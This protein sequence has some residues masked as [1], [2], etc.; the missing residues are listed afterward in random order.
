MTTFAT[1]YLKGP[2][3]DWWF[4]LPNFKEFVSLLTAQ[5]RDPAVEEVHEK[6]MFELR[7]ENGAATTYFQELEKLAKLA[8]QQRDEGERGVLVK[9]VRLGVPES[10]TRFIAF[11]GHGVPQTY[12]QWKARII[13]MHEERQ[14][15]WAFDQVT[16]SGPCDSCP[17]Q[18]GSSNTATSHN[19]TGGATSPSLAK[20]TSNAAPRDAASGKWM[21]FAGR[22]E[23]MD[24]GKLHAEGRCFRCKEKGHLGK[25]CPKKQEFK[26]IRS[27]YT[28]KQVKTE[29]VKAEESKV[30]EDLSTATSC[31]PTHSN[32]PA[33]T[34]LA[35]N[36]PHTTSTPVLESPNRYATLAIKECHDNNTTPLKGSTNGSPARAQAKVAK[37]AGHG[38]ES[39]IDA[40]D[41]GANHLTSNLRGATQ[42]VKVLDDKSPT[43]VTPVE[44]TGLAR[45]DGAREPGPN[46]SPEEAAPRV[47]K[48]AR[49]P[50]DDKK[51]LDAAGAATLI[52]PSHS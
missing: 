35:F 25:D 16:S 17:P 32:I 30:E 49:I 52:P 42:P 43:I 28:T 5:Y 29:E 24:I 21:T 47:E 22:G 15:K 13:A 46:S 38:T 20:P 3:K 11:Q 9:A 44:T 36:V 2:A 39:P 40:P 8:G 50:E 33:P 26:D 14:K 12:T 7:M 18:K 4:R 51:T 34:L 27:V 45:S 23:P 31:L 19:K 10:F 41:I 6:K 37:P 1:S 48:T